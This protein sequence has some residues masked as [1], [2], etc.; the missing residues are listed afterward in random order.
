MGDVEKS[1]VFVKP[2][3]VQKGLTGRIISRFEEKGFQIL[4][5]KK[6]QMKKEMA[7]EH[8]AEHLGKHFFETLIKFIT[9]SPIV[10]MI[11]EGRNAVE[12]VRKMCGVTDS[13][14]AEP[15]TIRGDFSLSGSENIIHASDSLKSADREI[16]LFQ[17]FLS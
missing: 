4:A 14:K 16:K 9:S 11:I 7:E 13:A 15:G 17:K 1:L 12:T 10:A 3:G 8:Y 2:D 6:F 5:L